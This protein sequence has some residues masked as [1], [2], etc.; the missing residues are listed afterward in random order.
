MSMFPQ[1]APQLVAN[2][3][4]PVPITPETKAPTRLPKWQKYEYAPG[5][6]ARFADCGTGILTGDVLGVDIDIPDAAVVKELL[7][8]LLQT[9]G[10]APVRFGNKPKALA[11]YHAAQ[12]AMT[13]KQTAVY[14]RGEL[15]GKVEVLAKGQQF[16]AYAIHP[17]IKQ[18]YEWRG[19]DPLTVSVD[20]LPMLTGE[21]VSEIIAHCA[22]LLAQWGEG[23]APAL[24]APSQLGG[25]FLPPRGVVAAENDALITQRQPATRAELLRALADLAEYDQGDYDSWREVGQIIHHETGGSNEG[26]EIFI[27]YS[28][29]L[30]GFN[31]GADAGEEGCR[32]KWRSF[33]RSGAKPV[34]F[35]TLIHK[36]TTLRATRGPENGGDLEG[37]ERSIPE[38][39]RAQVHTDLV[40][41]PACAAIKTASDED[42]ARAIALLSEG[43]LTQA[44]FHAMTGINPERMPDYLTDSA[45]LSA[46]QRASLQLRNSGAVARLEALRHSREAVQVAAQIMRDSEMHA[47]SR[48]SAA[49]FIAKVAGTERPAIELQQ[50]AERRSITINFGGR[51]SPVVIEG[52]CAPITFPPEE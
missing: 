28:R 20:K 24:P 2:G 22:A 52:D 3:Y 12:P 40:P 1:V 6:D 51:T 46:V 23:P 8:W 18:P 17:D 45:R 33:G 35:G 34:T 43:L 14:K 19:G 36:L 16:V 25:A 44:E 49:T 15:K 38:Q 10:M 13:K 4:R 27:K 39:V 26:L 32:A 30:S 21:Q 7:T 50:P 48:L 47:P 9:Y 41:A 31:A 29:C 11:L 42:I 5:D 37:P